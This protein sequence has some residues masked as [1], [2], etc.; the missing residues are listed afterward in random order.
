M[1]YAAP[2]ED[3][4]FI[5]HDVAGLDALI[6]DGLAGDLDADLLNALLD[7]AGNTAAGLLEPLNTL[8]DRTGSTLTGQGVVTPPGFPAAYAAWREGG[9]NGIDASTDHGGMGLPTAVSAAVM[10]IWNG[11]NMAFTLAPVLTQGAAE[12]IAAHGDAALKAAYLDKL[13]SGEWTAAMALTE[14]SAGS[15]LSN[16]RTKA[17]PAA[18]G[19]YRLFGSKIFITYGDHD[20]ADNIVHL[21]LARL[22]DAPAGTRGISLFLS[23]KFLPDGTRNDFRCTGLE[24]KLGIHASPTC[25]MTYGEN[26]GAV[27]WLVGAPNNGLA[28]M[29]TMM[30]RARLATGLQGVGVAEAATQHAYAYARDRRQGRAGEHAIAPIVEHPDVARMLLDMRSQTLA[31]RAIAYSA[32]LAI[33]RAVRETEPA[34]KAAASAREA[35]LIP[36]IKSYGSDI[37]V[38]VASTGVQVH[39]GMGYIEETGAA[40]FLRDARIVPIYEGTNGIQA[41]DL[42]GRKVVR[43]GGAA[44]CALIAELTAIASAAKG[45]TQLAQAPAQLDWALEALTQTTDWLLDAART[46]EERLGGATPY[47]TLFATTLGGALLIKGALKSNA[48]ADMTALARHYATTRLT[49]AGALAVQ[50]QSGVGALAAEGAMAAYS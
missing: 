33:D 47:L 18:D 46:E 42:V 49:H 8:G 40:Q 15:D 13:V 27:A 9:W 41:I 16:L 7:E 24:H 1:A 29:F 21:V 23:P 22:P 17:N 11:A 10:E 48:P 2:V 31:A 14:P 4:R 50:V 26:G 25:S 32:G 44:A 45:K 35:L 39:G 6:A 12:A 37:G 28:C 3:I 36:I 34:K 20:L 43:D 5:L 30:N 19:T 38:E